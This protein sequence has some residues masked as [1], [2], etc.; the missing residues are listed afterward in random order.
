MTTGLAVKERNVSKNIHDD[1]KAPFVQVFKLLF[2]NKYFLVALL[3][4]IFLYLR[5]ITVSAQ[6][7]YATYILNDASLMGLLSIVYTGAG[8]IG[9][10]FAPKLFTIFGGL[11]KTIT[12]GLF[13]SL[14]GLI[15]CAIFPE[16]VSMLLVG[17]AI[18]AIG[19]SILQGG[20]PAMVADVGDLIYWKSGV[21]V[22]GA[23]FSI[24][25]AGMKVG[26]GL[27]SALIGWLLAFGNYVP[28]ASTQPGSAIFAMKSLYIYLPILFT[29]VLLLLIGL[30]NLEK[31]M[32][33]VRDEIS[34]G[35][36]GENRDIPST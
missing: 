16:N 13:I 36:V 5:L 12:T 29:I 24:S 18:S 30:F 28:N 2:T 26:S 35:N 4:Y 22:Q 21:P 19:V 33:K 6:I 9:L 10:L 14:L 27:A 1:Q 11:R 20:L 3:T 23:V 31:F 34:I 7:F 25:S 15:V 8:V 17:L 32:P